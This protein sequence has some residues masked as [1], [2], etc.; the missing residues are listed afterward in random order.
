ML[1]GSPL[2]AVGDVYMVVPGFSRPLFNNKISFFTQ[3]LRFCDVQETF[4]RV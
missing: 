1:E 2:G 3:K 4:P